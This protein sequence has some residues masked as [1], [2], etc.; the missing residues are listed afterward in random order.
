MPLL[1][2]LSFLTKIKMDF[3]FDYDVWYSNYEKHLDLA[4][5]NCTINSAGKS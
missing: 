2:L 4:V 5:K 1:K 3:S